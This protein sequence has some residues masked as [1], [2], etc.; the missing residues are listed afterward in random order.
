MA[1][2]GQLKAS[3]KT[4]AFYL[5]QIVQGLFCFLDIQ[6]AN[7]KAN[8]DHNIVSDIG[9]WDIG[10]ANFFHHAAKAD[11]TPSAPGLAPGY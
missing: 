2:V 9:F 10:Q 1:I 4:G 7:G 8:V 6:L 5:V 3:L 11:T